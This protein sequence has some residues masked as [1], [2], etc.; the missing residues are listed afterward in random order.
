MEISGGTSY[1]ALN[2][3]EI[4]MARENS[5]K[6]EDDKRN[7]KCNHLKKHIKKIDNISTLFQNL[8]KQDFYNTFY[9]Q[10]AFKELLAINRLFQKLEKGQSYFV[11][12]R[13]RVFN[14]LI[15]AQS[16]ENY[17]ELYIVMPIYKNDNIFEKLSSKELEIQQKLIELSSKVKIEIIFV[18]NDYKKE[19]SLEF[20][21]FLEKSN[22]TINIYFALKSDIENEVNSIDFIFTDIKNYS[23]SRILR[24]SN[25][26]FHLLRH[27]ITLN[28]YEEMYQ[29]ILNRSLTYEEFFKNRSKLCRVS[30]PILEKLI[31]KWY[32]HLYGTQKFWIY[33]VVINR[34][35]TIIL[36]DENGGVKK[37]GDNL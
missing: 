16:Y 17:Q 26:V 4:I 31:G 35:N 22:K 34:D 12:N 27:D 18:I 23:I 9:K 8:S 6:F 28:Q 24:T 7:F 3:T 29:K 36:T 37:R 19:L 11:N 14:V 10:L 33:K 25:P 2:E 13:E 1:I 30:N 15:E 32:L 20:K 21:K 5:Y